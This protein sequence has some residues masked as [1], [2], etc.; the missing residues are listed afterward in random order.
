M[1][2]Q[3]SER[4]TEPLFRGERPHENHSLAYCNV[5]REG[6]T[7]RLWYESTDHTIK[8]DSDIF[9]CYAESRDGLHWHRP[10]L[11]LHEYEGSRKNNILLL[12]GRQYGG[13]HGHTVFIDEQA[14]AGERYKIVLS[15]WVEDRGWCVFGGT[16]ADGLRWHIFEEPI[17]PENSD[18]QTVCFRDAGTYRLY[19]R[20]WTEGVF[21]G[22]RIVGY[23]ESKDFTR[24]PKPS[25][26]LVPDDRDPPDMD[27]YNSAATKL[28]DGLYIVFSS[29]FYHKD[30]IVFP[31]AAISRD[32]TAFEKIGD[33][34][35]LSAG[36]VFGRFGI[37]VAPGA[38]PGPKPNSWWFYY[39]GTNFH[40][41]QVRPAM[42]LFDGGIG[43]FLAVLS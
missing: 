6:D 41:D 43:R 7:W 9:L 34:P 10:D 25:P 17:L 32:G 37:Y 5:I 11:G 1:Q 30:D 31:Q 33:R 36:P 42:N 38:V 22:K 21:Q 23:T 12:A 35:I 24:F 4:T 27:L 28:R 20:M 16:S 2:L 14:P 13:G 39:L 26:I 3:I 8:T 40:H 18:T 15:R 29:G 19:V